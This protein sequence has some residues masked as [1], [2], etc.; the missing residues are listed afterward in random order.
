[1]ACPGVFPG[2][3]AVACANLVCC[4]RWR[5]PIGNLMRDNRGDANMGATIR[6]LGIN[7][8]KNVDSIRVLKIDELENVAGGSIIWSTVVGSGSDHKGGHK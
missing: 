4:F 2:W 7:E 5:R 3:L 1:M 8:P 6:E